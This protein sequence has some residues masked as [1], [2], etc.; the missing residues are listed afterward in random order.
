MELKRGEGRVHR[1]DISPRSQVCPALRVCLGRKLHYS[2]AS[3]FFF[4][5]SLTLSSLFSLYCSLGSSARPPGVSIPRID[6]QKRKKKKRDVTAERNYLEKETSIYLEVSLDSLSYRRRMTRRDVNRISM[7]TDVLSSRKELKEEKEMTVSVRIRKMRRN[8]MF[9]RS[10]FVRSS[11]L[12][13]VLC[14]SSLSSRFSICHARV[15][16]KR[17]LPLF[18]GGIFQ[19][20]FSNS[21]C[22]SEIYR[23]AA[24]HRQS[25]DIEN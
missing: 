21:S 15:Q 23:I 13:S 12:P 25:W 3:F 5:L 8:F 4:P 18:V 2:F 22:S 10:L 19:P 11:R 14:R 1:R 6:R 20:S 17:Y 16:L 24:F 9:A 7:P